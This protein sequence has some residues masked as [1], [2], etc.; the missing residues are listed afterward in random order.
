MLKSRNYWTPA[1]VA[2]G[3]IILVIGAIF[4]WREQEEKARA[5]QAVA[6]AAPTT[7]D[8]SA[9]PAERRHSR[10]AA[11]P[12]VSSRSADPGPIATTTPAHS[13]P[14]M[15]PSRERV[16]WVFMGLLP[17]D[18]SRDASVTS[19]V[20]V[21]DRGTAGT[22]RFRVGNACALL[23]LPSFGPSASA[24]PC[25]VSLR[26][27]TLDE[28][29]FDL[30]CA[31]RPETPLAVCRLTKSGSGAVLVVTLSDKTL[32]D[33]DLESIAANVPLDAFDPDE[34]KI[35]RC[36]L[37]PLS[38]VGE[39][40]IG[41]DAD[42]LLTSTDARPFDCPWPKQV[43]FCVAG[44]NDWTPRKTGNSWQWTDP[45]S[46]AT[47]VMDLVID[48]K[49]GIEA[50]LRLDC[51]TL[52]EIR[53][54]S[55][56]SGEAAA[57]V[58]ELTDSLEGAERLCYNTQND[59][60]YQEDKLQDLKQQYASH[61]H[62]GANGGPPDV[63]RLRQL[64]LDIPATSKEIARLADEVTRLTAQAARYKEDLAKQNSKT[65]ETLG[66][67]RA[68]MN[69]VRNAFTGARIAVT[70]PW[71][72]PAGEYRVKFAETTLGKIR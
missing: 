47:V 51:P 33:Y 61:S 46:N 22:Y 44:A 19:V 49:P 50:E 63:V 69:A 25:P 48:C 6:D 28:G 70:D 36:L 26:L 13:S 29:L 9:P 39:F 40:A 24:C 71:A 53:D 59:R 10:K 7:Q 64:L 65:V 2:A 8:E 68:L 1:L 52:R 60:K 35:H 15:P 66:K 62:G 20:S 56:N 27:R 55:L 34:K 58:K 21:N 31:G 14:E 23:D 72:I 42:G 11:P 3:V 41:F 16:P 57:K 4:S 32:A 18:V 5:N 12:M 43:T 45:K 67:A 30:V 38:P 37:R 17:R 54:L